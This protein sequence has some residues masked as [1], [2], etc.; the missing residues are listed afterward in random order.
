MVTTT[1]NHPCKL[2]NQEVS[3]CIG[4]VL[5][6]HC[7]TAELCQKRANLEVNNSLEDKNTEEETAEGSS[8]TTTGVNAIAFAVIYNFA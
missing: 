3:V 4:D 1:L 6:E 7:W 8:A 5:D 2:V